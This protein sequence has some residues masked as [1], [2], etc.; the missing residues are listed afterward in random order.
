MH[1]LASMI[2][3]ENIQANVPLSSLRREA[4]FFVIMIAHRE[5][6]Q[7]DDVFQHFGGGGECRGS[8]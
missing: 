3:V 5:L 6:G 4:R 1:M 7:L 2:R 8:W